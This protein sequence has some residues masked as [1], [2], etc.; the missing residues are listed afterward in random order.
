ME[1]VLDSCIL[2]S[3]CDRHL[4]AAVRD[5]FSSVVEMLVIHSHSFNINVG[6]MQ[7][8]TIKEELNISS[9]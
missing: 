7:H 6:K 3:Q 9:E 5:V 8:S 2:S 1:L 4:T